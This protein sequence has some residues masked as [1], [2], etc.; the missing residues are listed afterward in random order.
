MISK[1]TALINVSVAPLRGLPAHAAEMV[2][3]ALMGQKAIVI[4]QHNEWLFCE[5]PDKYQGWI[6]ESLLVT[7]T[8]IQENWTDDSL[9]MVWPEHTFV[10]NIKKSTQPIADVCCGNLLKIKRILPGGHTEVVLPDG[11]KGLV[12]ANVLRPLF[13]KASFMNAEYLLK[14]ARRWM[15]IPYLWGGSSPKGFDCSGFVQLAYQSACGVLLPRDAWQ[16][17]QKGMTVEQN[18]DHLQPG[19]LLF[20]GKNEGKI[21]HVAICESN[22]YYLHADGMVG[23]N[24]L[25]PDNPLFNKYRFDTWQLTKRII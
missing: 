12:H 24:S 14:K 25:L 4:N 13:D 8:H 7:D 9:K 20:F 21:T 19:D 23:R 6:N 17:A 11:R 16:Q 1:K 3:Q 15:G 22:G 2:S 10:Y 5:M 18:T